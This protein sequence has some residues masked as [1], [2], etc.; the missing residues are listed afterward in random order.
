LTATVEAQLLEGLLVAI[1]PFT[2]TL[3]VE[4]Q[5]DDLFGLP[6]EVL[7]KVLR[8]GDS[9]EPWIQEILRRA[10]DSDERWI[11]EVIIQ[12]VIDRAGD[13]DERWIQLE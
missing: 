13:S 10:G 7:P 3:S 4:V 6:P 2:T 9:D 12:E 8:A 11:Q 1:R 5:A